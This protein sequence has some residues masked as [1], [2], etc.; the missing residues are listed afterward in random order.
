MRK[1]LIILIFSRIIILE[2]TGQPNESIGIN[3]FNISDLQPIDPLFRVSTSEFY[4]LGIPSGYINQI[5]DTIILIGKYFYCFLDTVTY[6]AIVGDTGKINLDVYAIDRN[7]NRLYEVYWVDNGPDYIK[8]GLFRIVRD[9]KIGYANAK[10][11]IVIQPQFDCAGSFKN[12]MAK[13]AYDCT[14]IKDFEY[15][16]MKSESW[17]YI[18]KTGKRIKN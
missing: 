16:V 15:P 2:V 8:D 7:E 11:E 4:E 17:F 10:G 9:E 14:S 13:V 18:D 6:F 1:L 12:G 5:G 3:Y